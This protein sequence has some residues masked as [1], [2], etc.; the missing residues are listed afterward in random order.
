MK[1]TGVPLLI[2]FSR[3]CTAKIFIKIYW[4]VEGE[5]EQVSEDVVQ[6]KSGKLFA[7]HSNS[8]YVKLLGSFFTFLLQKPMFPD[9]KK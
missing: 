2:L 6:Q 9:F 5:W 8:D 3:K 7:C 1:V 4:R